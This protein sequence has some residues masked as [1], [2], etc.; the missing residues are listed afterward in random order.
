MAQGFY[1]SRPIRHKLGERPPR[2]SG[3]ASYPRPPKRVRGVSL[4]CDKRTGDAFLDPGLNCTQILTGS[5]VSGEGR[6]A[7]L[8]ALC[9]GAGFILLALAGTASAQDK[10]KVIAERQDFMKKQTRDWIAIRNYL[11]GNA[12]Q[13]TASAAADSLTK[14][15]PTTPDHFPPGTAGP[16]PDGKYATKPEVWSEHD[17]FVAAVK[18][19]GEQVAA[20]DAAIKSGDKPKTEAAF[21]DLDGCNACH[22]TFRAKLQ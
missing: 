21:K 7:R 9:A 19:V 1:R 2:L 3:S 11:A 5:T 16:A 17:K 8:G 15:V 6:M 12:D 13:Q 10:D 18:K 4:I 20:L 22:N 14:S